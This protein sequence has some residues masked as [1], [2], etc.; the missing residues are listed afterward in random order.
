[1][2]D[3]SADRIVA[4]PARRDAGDA[5][6]L[7]LGMIPF[8]VVVLAEPDVPRG[9]MRRDLENIRRLGFN[10]I[11]LYPAVSRW[12]GAPPGH[13]AFGAIDAILADCVELGLKVILELQGQ[14][15]QHQDA[16]EC[17][18]LPPGFPSEQYRDN[19]F[20]RPEKIALVARY[21][22]EVAT[23]FKG[24]PALLAY[25]LFNEIGNEA[26]DPG[27][28]AAFVAFLRRQYEE[29]IDALNRAWATYFAD[30]E[31]IGRMPPQYRAWNW[32]SVLAQRDWLRFRSADFA[33]Q[34]AQW[35]AIIRAID[36]TT[37]LFV[38]VL[39]SDV[40]H[41]RTGAYFGVSDWDA[42]EPSDVLGL[43]CYANMLAPDWWEHDAW[44]WPQFWRHALGAAGGKQVIISELMTHN[45]SLFPREKSSMTDE[46]RLWG[47][48]AIFHGIQGVVYWKYRPFRRGR[49][50]AGRGLT[51][52]DGTPNRF[53]E[54]AAEVAVFVARHAEALARAVPDDAG[55]AILHDP[56]AERLYSA[57]G[58]GSDNEGPSSFYTDAHRGFFRGW[59]MC[60]ISPT[61]TTPARWRDGVP[62]QIGVLAV[63]CLAPVSA[64][65][66][67]A[68]AAFVR[69]GGVLV[70]ESRFGR[71]DEDGNL[72]P[73]APGGGLHEVAGFE[74]VEFTARFRDALR[75][76][77]AALEFGDDYFQELRLR[78]NVEAPLRTEGGAPALIEAR[79]GAGRWLHVPFLLSHKIQQDAAGALEFFARL[80][81]RVA[82]ALRAAVQV[83]RKPRAV[84]VSVLL[85]RTTRAPIF[86]GLCNYEHGANETVLRAAAR[87]ARV[88]SAAAVV[89]AREADGDWRVRMPP[90]SAAAVFFE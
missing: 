49:Q 9:E 30:F 26:R 15:P 66:A 41:P 1:M 71:L 58:V 32:S 46:V 79:I 11:V 8:G 5:G 17:F 6:A 67:A 68:L 52:A 57:L 42:V 31:S 85:D 84:D 23:H 50:V 56:E 33:A 63:P 47:Y 43:S 88:E 60:G 21:L 40:L 34:I 86:A 74:E 18:E 7:A 80:H 69:R 59:W 72:W 10:T 64:R 28:V 51:D 70:T 76:G 53:G 55:C 61:Y 82:P 22:R 54:Q 3:T 27:T 89:L 2:S 39:G 81:E 35:R 14:L 44:L 36:A 78:D 19:G 75:I 48:Q 20:H 73:H 4:A 87:A 45:R 77:D 24:H 65:L 90:R 16:P 37:P 83:V 25:D 29:K 38:D 13:T 62:A 12:E